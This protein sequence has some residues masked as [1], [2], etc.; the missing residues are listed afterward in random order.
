MSAEATVIRD[1][2]DRVTRATK[3][4]FSS[5][6]SRWTLDEQFQR[7]MMSE[8]RCYED[9]HRFDFISKA[10]LPDPG[11]T[12]EQRVLRAGA[13]FSSSS[14][15]IAPGKLVYYAHCEV[16]PLRTLRLTDDCCSV[17]IGFTYL[18]A[19]LPPRLYSTT[20]VEVREELKH[21]LND[22]LV[23]AETQASIPAAAPTYQGYTQAQWDEWNRSR[24]G[25]RYTQAEWDAW[26]RDLLPAEEGIA[27]KSRVLLVDGV[28]MAM[29]T[30]KQTQ[31]DKLKEVP[32]PLPKAQEQIAE[33]ESSIR[34]LGGSSEAVEAL[35]EDLSGQVAEAFSR[36]EWYTRWGVHF[37]PSLLCAHASQQCNNFKDPGVQHY[38][39]DLFADLRDQA[40][41]GAGDATNRGHAQ[42][43]GKGWR[44]WKPEST[45]AVT[46]IT[47][48]LKKTALQASFGEFGRIIRIEVPDGKTVA[49]VEFEEHRDA[50]DAVKEMHNALVEGRRIGVRMVEDL[51]TKQHR[52]R[53]DPPDRP[54]DRSRSQARRSRR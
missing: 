44:P 26:L 29:S 1:A 47:D 54:R 4:N 13:H 9:M 18:G 6:A 49:F 14:Q 28:R 8:G 46:G 33:L 43:S 52:G 36:E 39:G 5:L 7:R 50:N 30:L 42:G 38:G 23:S 19:F 35:L 2:K 10:C 12:E 22:S 51:E 45:V 15:A 20:N 40:D 25:R 37:L 41:E 31:L 27:Q 53:E 48:K 24:Q 11:R 17:P 21:I 3:L 32:L 16:E 34:A